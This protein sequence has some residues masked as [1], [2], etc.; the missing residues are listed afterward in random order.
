MTEE[1]FQAHLLREG[2]ISDLP[3]PPNERSGKR[4][5]TPIN[6]TGAPLSETIIEER[7]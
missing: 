6:V 4:D 2:V 1:E 3:K 7:R 5:F